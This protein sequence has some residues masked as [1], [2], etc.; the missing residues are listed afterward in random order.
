[1]NVT[2][3]YKVVKHGDRHLASD[4]PSTDSTSLD[5]SV[6]FP[7]EDTWGQ[8]TEYIR[9]RDY[10]ELMPIPDDVYT[11]EI[12]YKYDEAELVDADDEPGIPIIVNKKMC[13]RHKTHSTCSLNGLKV[14]R[15]K[16]MKSQSTLILG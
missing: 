6:N 2:K 12:F 16:L 3:G 8:P 14:S 9:Y 4:S 13:L 15:T 11:M 7:P 5:D 10:M 1:M